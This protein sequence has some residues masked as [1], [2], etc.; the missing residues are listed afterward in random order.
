MISLLKRYTKWLHTQWPAGHVEKLPLVNEDGST[1]V[2][3]LYIVGDLTGIPLLKFSSH[4]GAKA[5]RKIVEDPA[6][7]QRKQDDP[8]VYDLVVVGAGVSGV[9][10]I[11][12][13]RQ[14][15]LK[16]EILEA[17]EPFSTI[18][19]FPRGKPI[20]TY[21]TDMTP[22]G[23]LQFGPKSD[24]K[25]GL[26]QELQDFLSQRDIK[27]RIA[28]VNQI[29][30]RRGLLEIE[31]DGDETIKS[32]RVIV[33]IG[34]SGNYR[35]LGISGED[36]DIVYNRLHDPK[37]FCGKNIVIVG[38]G[39][40]A[41]ETAIALTS[42]GSR[43][44][45]S[46][47]KAQ[48]SRPKP[49]NVDKINALTAQADADVEVEQATDEWV[50]SAAGPYIPDRPTDDECEGCGGKLRG[51]PADGECPGC[52]KPFHRRIGGLQLMM[53]SKPKQIND[54]E[55]VITNAKGTDETIKAEAVFVMI[56]REA[57]LDFFRR[58]G[59]RIRG[60]R[61][62][63]WWMTLIL[64]LVAF[65]FI[66]HWKKPGVWLPIG[67][68]F[69]S[70]GLFPYKVPQWLNSVS[71]AFANPAHLLGTLN[72]SLASPGFYYSLLYC[73]VMLGFGIRRIRRRRTPYVTVQTWTLLAIQ[74]IPLF[75]LP[76]ILLPWLGNNGAYDSGA[77]KWLADQLFPLVDWDLNG[78]A[79]Y[80]AFGLILAWP[81]F[82][83]NVFTDQPMWLWLGIS[84][85]QTFVIIPLIIFRWGKG[86]YCGWICSCGGMAETLGDAHRYKMPH[87]PVWNRMNMIGQVFLAVCF[88]LLFTRIISWVWPESFVGDT[89]HAVLKGFPVLNYA[90]FID[91][92]FAGIL[93]FGLYFHFSGRMWCRFACPLAALMHIYA[94]FS[95]FRIISEKSKCIS[96]NVCTTV[97]H[98]GIDV[99][100]FANKG[101]PMEDPQCVRCSACVQSCPTGVLEFGRINRKTGEVIARDRLAASPILMAEVTVNGNQI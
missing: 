16:A 60:E 97:C 89:Y 94:R 19:N 27:P 92:L 42:C 75:I 6:F 3:G 93:G 71:E 85:L 34:R 68:Y 32:H 74:I 28:H 37:D 50:A 80:H 8:D 62:L 41:L 78:R 39:D 90:W 59:V 31:L 87:G 26:V 11:A 56:G 13:A 84:F 33:G 64:V 51:Y 82:V 4:S 77:M 63:N 66:Y 91:L 30:R 55:V 25:E 76:Y 46:Y 21:P 72:N 12:E 96:C 7:K 2:P 5:V 58:S 20:Y 83:W 65:V 10:A 79:Y 47:R 48:F 70:H 86:A 95:Q 23:E 81:L 36:R 54:G 52:G 35:T 73:V 45:L 44:T 38:G 53:A 14:I 99:M 61:S 49:E 40:N 18:V 100:S 17:S 29:V 22:D 101:I 24:I 88:F 98:Q 57:P 43:V 9:A 1:N 69:Q 67:D 15:G